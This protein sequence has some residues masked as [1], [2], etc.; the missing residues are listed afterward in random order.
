MTNLR[1][2]IFYKY[3]NL[4]LEVEMSMVD[5]SRWLKQRAELLKSKRWESMRKRDEYWFRKQ[6]RK[7]NKDMK[8]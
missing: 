3:C 7:N 1:Y 8:S 4:M 6:L 5:L 2:W